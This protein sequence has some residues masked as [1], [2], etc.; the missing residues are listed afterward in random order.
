MRDVLTSVDCNFEFHLIYN[1]ALNLYLLQ[2][3]RFLQALNFFLIIILYNSLRT[4]R[5]MTYL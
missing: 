4:M 1:I 2:D 5:F 3:Y